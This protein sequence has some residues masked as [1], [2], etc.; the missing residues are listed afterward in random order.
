MRISDWSSDVCSSD[1][2]RGWRGG[3]ARTRP[4]SS[5]RRPT[6]GSG[7]RHKTLACKDL[8]QYEVG[9]HC[10]QRPALP[11]RQFLPTASGALPASRPGP[12]AVV[13]CSV[14]P[15]HARTGSGPPAHE[16]GTIT[17]RP[18]DSPADV[19]LLGNAPGE[20]DRSE[21][22]TATTPES[23]PTPEP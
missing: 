6:S 1:L 19:R 17:F 22:L 14:S 5:S 23:L 11:A 4:S 20:G 13:S 15:R 7:Q 8:Q 16:I 3:T 10:R 9:H 2:C 21:S 18:P 12:L